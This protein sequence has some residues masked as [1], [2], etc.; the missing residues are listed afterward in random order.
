MKYIIALLMLLLVS[1]PAVSAD[2]AVLGSKDSTTVVSIVGELVEGDF[3]KFKNLLENL[4]NK[5]VVV[6]VSGPGGSL[7]ESMLIGE[8]I[9]EHKIKTVASGVCASGC[10]YIWLAGYKLGVDPETKLGFHSAYAASSDKKPAQVTGQGNALL[11]AYLSKLGYDYDLIAYVT[12]AEL[13]QMEWMTASSARELNLQFYIVK[14]KESFDNF[15]K[16]I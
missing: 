2:V 4:N 13:Q 1:T 5:N 3:N 9:N 16:L 15:I 12:M 11:G 7:I 14:D 6:F 8:Y 10:A